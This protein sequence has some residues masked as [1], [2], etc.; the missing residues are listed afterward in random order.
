MCT[1]LSIGTP[2]LADLLCSIS[3]LVY[4]QSLS[5]PD[6]EDLVCGVGYVSFSGISTAQGKKKASEGILLV[7]YMC[8]ELLAVHLFLACRFSLSLFGKEPLADKESYDERYPHTKNAT[9]GK[10]SVCVIICDTRLIYIYCAPVAAFS[11]WSKPLNR[12]A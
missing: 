9:S 11:P 5:F 8:Y 7:P 10:K 2:C 6:N 4:N 1:A 3:E 12:L